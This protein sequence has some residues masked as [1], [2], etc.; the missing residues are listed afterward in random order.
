MNE[1]TEKHKSQTTRHRLTE[2]MKPIERTEENRI[3][4]RKTKNKSG[5]QDRT[6]ERNKDEES[7]KANGETER[8]QQIRKSER[9]ESND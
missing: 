9:K 1:T 3:P 4:G 6:K 2:R 7:G 5:A 8:L